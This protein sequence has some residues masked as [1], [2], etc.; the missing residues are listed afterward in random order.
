MG[1]PKLM[2]DAGLSLYMNMYIYIAIYINLFT[3]MFHCQRLSDSKLRTPWA[4]NIL[5]LPNSKPGMHPIFGSAH[6]LRTRLFQCTESWFAKSEI[7]K[8]SWTINKKTEMADQAVQLFWAFH[9]FG[10]QVSH[11]QQVQNCL[12]VNCQVNYTKQWFRGLKKTIVKRQLWRRMLRLGSNIRIQETTFRG[13]LIGI[14]RMDYDHPE[15]IKDTM[16]LMPDV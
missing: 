8:N 4:S 12:K 11:K 2:Q 3:A 14:P 16:P 1:H 6:W 13:W 9:S 10:F 15:Q 7:Q 5:W